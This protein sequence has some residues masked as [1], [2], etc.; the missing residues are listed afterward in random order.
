MGVSEAMINCYTE[1]E[2][3]RKV[4]EK[5]T[6]FLT[7]YARTY[8]ALGANGVLMAEPLTGLM[9]PALAEE[10]SAPYVK[11]IID[12]V[13]DDGFAVIYH[14]CGNNTVLMLKEILSQGAYAYHFGNAVSMEDVLANVPEDTIVLGNVDPARQLK[15]GTPES[16]RTAT[17]S[18]LETC[19]KHRNFIISSGCD[20]PP[21]APWE[22]IDAFFA[23]AKEFYG[24]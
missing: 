8:K 12:A 2:M 24:E 3:V 10:F 14:N 15:N 21:G 1:P 17:L 20:I 5:T 13:Q 16:V 4:M 11:K 23:A 7:E 18:L 19:A 22:N 6:A 9:S